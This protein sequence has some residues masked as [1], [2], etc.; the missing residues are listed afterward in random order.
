MP[1][2]SQYLS[3]R[4]IENLEVFGM[5][6][7]AATGPLEGAL[8]RLQE[9]ES[10]SVL[11]ALAKTF[12]CALCLRRCHATHGVSLPPLRMGVRRGVRKPLSIGN[13]PISFTSTLLGQRLGP[14][15]VC[16]SERA[17]KDLLLA[18]KEGIIFSVCSPSP[19]VYVPSQPQA[20]YE[21]AVD[22]DLR[23]MHLACM[24]VETPLSY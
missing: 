11:H 13:L 6:A 5:R 18:N 9:R 1:A 12:P 4:D 8:A 2:V 21:A 19:P 20:M 10:F 24:C 14:W 17:L 3:S 23:L 16:L 15:R 22:G 7:P